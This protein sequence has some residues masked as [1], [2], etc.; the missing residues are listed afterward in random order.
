VNVARIR[1]WPTS[2]PG[3]LVSDRVGSILRPRHFGPSTNLYICTF[4][5]AATSP[6]IRPYSTTG[7]E[8]DVQYHSTSYG[9]VLGPDVR[10]T[11]C[12]SGTSSTT[13]RQVGAEWLPSV[14]D[15]Q[16][17]SLGAGNWVTTCRLLGMATARCSIIQPAYDYDY[18][19]IQGCSTTPVSMVVQ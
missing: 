9:H 12:A 7:G 4:N 14:P 5:T 17:P 15:F 3:V 18:T 19:E 16:G 10:E 1:R 6:A 2:Q 8:A 13:T 11:I